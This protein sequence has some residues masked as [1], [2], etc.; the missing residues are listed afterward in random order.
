MGRETPREETYLGHR[1]HWQHMT[2]D[3]DF[4]FNTTTDKIKEINPVHLYKIDLKS[5]EAHSHPTESQIKIFTDGSLID[6]HAGSGFTIQYK[7]K[8][9]L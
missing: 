9:I 7:K 1:L 2:D 3:T 6:Q 8:E 5:L 4:G